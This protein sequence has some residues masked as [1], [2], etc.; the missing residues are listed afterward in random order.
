MFK[1]GHVAPDGRT[2]LGQRTRASDPHLWLPYVTARYI[3]A[4]ANLSPEQKRMVYE[5]N[6]RRVYPRLDAAL[7]ARGL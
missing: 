4:T 3:E 5:L 7:K 6:A 1:W 2:G